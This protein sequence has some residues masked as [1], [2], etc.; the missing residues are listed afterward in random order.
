MNETKNILP[1][2]DVTAMKSKYEQPENKASKRNR[3]FDNSPFVILSKHLRRENKNQNGN[4]CAT[5]DKYL[6][7][8]FRYCKYNEIDPENPTVENIYDF[9]DLHPDWACGTKRSALSAFRKYYNK[10]RN[11]GLI[12]N[13][14]LPYEEKPLVYIS[15]EELEAFFNSIENP[16][17]RLILLFKYSSG[18][19]STEL[20]NMRWGDIN[21][22]TA[23]G[24]L[25]NTKNRTD[26]VILFL[27][28]GKDLL[29]Q[30]KEYRGSAKDGDYIFPNIYN[31]KLLWYM[32]H[33]YAVKF[34][35]PK[36]NPHNLRHAFATHLAEIGL[37]PYEITALLGQ[38]HVKS[39]EKYINLIKSNKLPDLVD[40]NPLNKHKILI[41]REGL[42]ETVINQI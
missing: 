26:R 22:D 7:K 23:K 18:I 38:K 1:I 11:L 10:C 36:I 6:V 37:T 9:F 29:Q 41:L 3:T 40:K 30:L 32:C 27:Y 2:V 12:I 21:I 25:Y 17:D 19:R 28:N 20:A 39:S 31:D 15:S 14:D 4:T 42:T 24:M 34:G 13:M 5:Y 33:K 35:N 16:Y 8:F